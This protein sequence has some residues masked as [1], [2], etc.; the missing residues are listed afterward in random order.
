MASDYVN[1]KQMYR[2]MTTPALELVLVRLKT[3]LA[4]VSNDEEFLSERVRALEA[5]LE[6]RE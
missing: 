6:E 5:V 2:D 1:A 3:D 4:R